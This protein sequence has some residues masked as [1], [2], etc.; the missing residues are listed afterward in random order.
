VLVELL[1]FVPLAVLS[2]TA[3]PLPFDHV[4]L[5]FAAGHSFTE[6]C[7]FAGFGS[8]CAGVAALVDVAVLGAV[9][10]RWRLR[11][12]AESLP[13]AGRG[14][15]VAVILVALL[16]IPYT[17]IRLAL[18][19]V[20]PR[21]LLYA[22]LVSV[23]RLPRYL[24]LIRLWQALALPGWVGG[25]LVLS[26]L[27]WI[28]WRPRRTMTVASRTLHGAVPC[29]AGHAHFNGSCHAGYCFCQVGRRSAVTS[30]TRE[31]TSSP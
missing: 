25:L 1:W 29:Q 22:M 12:K 17:T 27:G 7:V 9:G 13:W 5:W 3:F 18:L 15:Y 6:A 14:F 28:A 10:R 24:L 20:R 26:A 19:R 11:A 30:S 8:A 23:A 31:P 4:L 21:P 2:N 16:P